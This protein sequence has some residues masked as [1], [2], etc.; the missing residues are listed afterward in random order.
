MNLNTISLPWW[1]RPIKLCKVLKLGS[2]YREIP[3][4]EGGRGPITP[5]PNR[6]NLWMCY[7]LLGSML[8]LIRNFWKVLVRQEHENV[9]FIPSCSKKLGGSNGGTC[10]T[11][12]H[13]NYRYPL[14]THLE[15]GI[16][17]SGP[18]W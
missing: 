3:R 17:S 16:I 5:F 6:D 14:P 15:R 18:K 13:F 7:H 4:G 11:S 8:T 10:M 1:A 2:P 12:S 9:S